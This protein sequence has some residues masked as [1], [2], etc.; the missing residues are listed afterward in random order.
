MASVIFLAMKP[1]TLKPV[2]SAVSE[3]VLCGYTRAIPPIVGTG[4]ETSVS[5]LPKPCAARSADTWLNF[6][7]VTKPM[8]PRSIATKSHS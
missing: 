3:K 1:G 5:S 8:T 4:A 6:S 7:S 2:N